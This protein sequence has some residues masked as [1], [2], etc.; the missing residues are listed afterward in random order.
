[1][2]YSNVGHWVMVE[3]AAEFNQIALGFLRG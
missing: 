3:R 1:V 2:T